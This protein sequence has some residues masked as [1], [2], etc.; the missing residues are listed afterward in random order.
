MKRLKESNNL[1]LDQFRRWQYKAYANN[2]RMDLLAWVKPLL[3]VSR[4]GRVRWI[5]KSKESK[6]T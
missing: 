2:V 3:E 1:L 5:R 4:S 6:Q